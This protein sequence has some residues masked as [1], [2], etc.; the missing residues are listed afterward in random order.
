[1]VYVKKTNYEVPKL[2]VYS[3]K[4]GITKIIQIINE[5]TDYEISRIFSNWIDDYIKR[6]MDVADLN[7]IMKDVEKHNEFVNPNDLPE[8]NWYTFHQAQIDLFINIT[9]EKLGKRLNYD[10]LFWIPWIC[11]L[12]NV[13]KP[14]RK[15]KNKISKEKKLKNIW[16]SNIITA[17]RNWLMHNRYIMKRDGIYIHSQKA[18]KKKNKEKDANWNYIVQEE[19]FE[20][21]ISYDFFSEI[22]KFCVNA[23]RKFTTYG[24]V[25]DNIN[26]TE[27]FDKNLVKIATYE[28]SKKWDMSK[29]SLDAMKSVYNRDIWCR[30]TDLTMWQKKFLSE[31]FGVY[32]FNRKNLEFVNKFMAYDDNRIQLNA[33]CKTNLATILDQRNF[34]LDCAGNNGILKWMIMR[35]TEWNDINRRNIWQCDNDIENEV[36][37]KFEIWKAFP[38]QIY[39]QYKNP[40][41]EKY[42]NSF[43]PE[44]LDK[45]L[46]LKI[47]ETIIS[48]IKRLKYELLVSKDMY[49][50]NVKLEF[51]RVYLKAL[52]LSKFYINNPKLGLVL[53]QSQKRVWDELRKQ[54]RDYIMN[55]YIEIP[56]LYWTKEA[57]ERHIDKNLWDSYR[58]I[59]FKDLTRWNV[60]NWIIKTTDDINQ[61]M[62][63]INLFCTKEAN[64]LLPKHKQIL[65][66]NVKKVI[67]V[68]KEKLNTITVISEDEHIRNAF[69]HHHYTILPWFNKILLWDP[70]IDDTPNWENIYDLNELYKNAVSRVNEDFLD[71]KSED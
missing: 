58:K 56:K 52:Y 24:F 17:I 34:F 19:S 10:D 13:I 59:V 36:K 53:A 44:T 3:G 45:I 71:L 25:F 22:I 49:S 7:S 65:L 51:R 20:A 63:K 18:F 47:K 60:D 15:Y 28:K 70:S 62:S 61:I 37:R 43:E 64:H 2:E 5:S 50:G 54:W 69:A 21:I 14:N 29:S 27:W 8:L 42:L 30:E 48:L 35:F 55:K 9:E 26:R 57:K 1:M 6:C 66:D 38:H 46:P 68:R 41:A 16:F 33:I 32:Q 23:D 4:N 40:E 31:Y 12:I 67:K 11:D 39:F